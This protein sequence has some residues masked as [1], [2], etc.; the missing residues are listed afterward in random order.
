M[1]ADRAIDG[2]SAV[3]ERIGCSE[4]PS[5]DAGGGAPAGP[6]EPHWPDLCGGRIVKSKKSSFLV[7]SYNY[8]ATGKAAV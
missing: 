6:F 3:D 4:P 8:T 1:V 5:N 7:Y 2:R